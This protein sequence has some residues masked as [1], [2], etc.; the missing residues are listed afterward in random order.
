MGDFINASPISSISSVYEGMRKNG[1]VVSLDGHGVDEM[2]YGYRDMVYGLYNNALW[3]GSM[4][5]TLEY[6][7][8]L[9]AMYHPDSRQDFMVKSDRH[10]DEKKTRESGLK[11]KFKKIVGKELVSKEFLPIDLPSLSD[12]PYD[13]S[14]KPVPER[15][16]YY[17]FF[18]H[19]LPALLRN[20]DRAGMM[21]SIEIR[22]PFMDWRLVSYVFSLPISSKVGNG[23]TKLILREA[24]KGKMDE[25]LR[26]RTYKVGIGSPIEH[27]MNGSLKE[28]AL[29]M[30]DRDQKRKLE[31]EL[32][33]RGHWSAD[34]V[35][36]TWQKINLRLIS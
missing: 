13:F 5:N 34:L 32:T 8:V 33:N 1:I 30:S 2:L 35:R 6:R 20:F 23:Y 24:M 10:Q 15:M 29:D 18:Q 17:E 12:K 19:T 11:H 25:S 22:M 21:N 28:W 3:S 36:E 16:L 31:T 9:S 27:W 4:I 26:T 7:N 14:E